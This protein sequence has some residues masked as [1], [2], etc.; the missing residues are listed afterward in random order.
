LNQ[1]VIAEKPSVGKSLA[2]VL[3][4][5]GREDGYFIGNGYIVSWCFGHLAELVSADAYDEKYGKWR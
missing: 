5:N 3:G 4:A 2:A 1:L